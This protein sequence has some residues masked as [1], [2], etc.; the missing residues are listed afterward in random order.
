MSTVQHSPLDSSGSFPPKFQIA[1]NGVQNDLAVSVAQAAKVDERLRAQARQIGISWNLMEPGDSH[2]NFARRLATASSRISRVTERL[3]ETVLSG[4]T[5]KGDGAVL[6]GHLMPIRTALRECRQA[7]RSKSALPRV[8]LD[9][10][11][12]PVPRT[13]A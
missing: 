4:T 1:A 9:D 12:A 7:L 3:Q 5:V 8:Q 10:R 13:Y 11:K 6:L 2:E